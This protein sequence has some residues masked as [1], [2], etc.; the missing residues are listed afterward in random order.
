[1]RRAKEVGVGGAGHCLGGGGG[2]GGERGHAC[3]HPSIHR[4]VH[5]FFHLSSHLIRSSIY[6]SVHPSIHHSTH[7]SLSRPTIHPSHPPGF[8]HHIM[9]PLIPFT[10]IRLSIPL[11]RFCVFVLVLEFLSVLGLVPVPFLLKQL[12][13]VLQVIVFATCCLILGLF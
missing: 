6:P 1:M 13:V 5:P 11:V 12:L 10:S 2:D 8:H 3:I 9:H 4:P 7:P